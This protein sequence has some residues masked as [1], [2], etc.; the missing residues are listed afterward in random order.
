MK[1]GVQFRADARSQSDIESLLVIEGCMSVREHE[2]C[3]R[4]EFGDVV[5]LYYVTDMDGTKI[6]QVSALLANYPAVYIG[7]L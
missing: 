3:N 7:P 4:Y 2:R 1:F 6:A 5:V